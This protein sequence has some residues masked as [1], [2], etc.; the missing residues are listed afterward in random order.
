MA[1][2]PTN[3]DI[4]QGTTFSVLAVWSNED[5]SV[6]DISNYSARMQIRSSYASNTVV[7][8]LTTAN[9]EITVS[10]NGQFTLALSAERTAKIPVDYSSTSKPP[11]TQYVYDLEMIDPDQNVIRLMFGTINVIGEVTR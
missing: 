9:G 6:K 1:E 7:E 4:D 10:S 3:L 2:K 8:S 11:K 5:G